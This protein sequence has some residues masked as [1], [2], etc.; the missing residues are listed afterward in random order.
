M[1]SHEI[2]YIPLHIAIGRCLKYYIPSKV[3]ASGSGTTRTT[4][5]AP[6]VNAYKF[7]KVL[8]VI[9]GTGAGIP[10]WVPRPV[11]CRGTGQ[12]APLEKTQ[13]A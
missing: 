11:V 1:H 5:H 13:T 12:I 10:R 4:R 2:T 3:S 6:G 8:K 7:L 9:T